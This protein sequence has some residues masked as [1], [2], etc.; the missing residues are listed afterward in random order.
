M[1]QVFQGMTIALVSTKE[2]SANATQKQYLEKHGATVV[3]RTKPSFFCSKPPALEHTTDTL[4][5]IVLA[6]DTT[7]SVP[8]RDLRWLGPVSENIPLALSYPW[9]VACV[10]GGKVAAVDNYTVELLT[11]T[12]PSPK[13]QR[14][15]E[16]GDAAVEASPA[17]AGATVPDT[18]LASPVAPAAPA[19]ARVPDTLVA[20]VNLN[21]HLTR[22][23]SEMRDWY[24]LEIETEK[25]PL[26]A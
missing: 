26:T 9:V 14:T 2:K 3:Q 17:P 8:R 23:L 16:G 19:A 12:E 22:P 10:D 15:D 4:T 6:D 18:A 20:E 7:T 1:T 25:G 13:K 11:D 24:K 5:H 21:E